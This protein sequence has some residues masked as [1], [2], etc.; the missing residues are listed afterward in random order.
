MPIIDYKATAKKEK[1]RFFTLTNISEKNKAIIKDFLVSYETSRSP[2]RMSLFLRHIRKFLEK[3]SDVESLIYSAKD[4]SQEELDKVKQYKLKVDT[5]FNNLKNEIGLNYYATVVNVSLMLV[6][7]LHNDTLPDSFKQIKRVEKKKQKRHLKSSDM[8]AWE[9]GLKASNT[10]NN[11]QSKAIILTQLDAGMR[12]SEFLDLNYGDVRVLKDVIA[13][14]DKATKNDKADP[15]ILYRSV[16][17]FLK[18]FNNH[19]TKNPDDPLW[20][21]QNEKSHRKDKYKSNVM[22]LT[23]PALNKMIKLMTEKGNIKKPF[24]FYNLRHS[25]CYLDKIE[26]LPVELASKRHRHSTGFFI[27]TYGRLDVMDTADR[28][29]TH[30]GIAK[31]NNKEKPKNRTCEMCGYVNEPDKEMCDK[32]NRPLTLQKA[33]EMQTSPEEALKSIISNP[34]MLAQLQRALNS[35]KEDLKKTIEKKEKTKS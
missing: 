17:Y 15:V 23:Y 10:T 29:R 24:D 30:Y 25:S 4:H 32:C 20:L 1:E 7:N 27:D 21:L 13:L 33:M 28:Y 34:E 31:E 26:N 11:I 16:P 35:N 8:W 2:A 9:D 3:T 14:E 12:P 6:K 19:P 18:W 22:R 5:I